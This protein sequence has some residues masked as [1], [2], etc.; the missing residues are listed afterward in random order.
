MSEMGKVSF[1][2]SEELEKYKRESTNLEFVLVTGG[3]IIGKIIWL[4]GQSIGIIN[5]CNQKIILYKHSIAFIQERTK[6]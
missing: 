6:E 2:E 5:D 3:L 1:E 4:G